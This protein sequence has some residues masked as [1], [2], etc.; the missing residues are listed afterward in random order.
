MKS[1][2]WFKIHLS[3]K[4]LEASKFWDLAWDRTGLVTSSNNNYFDCDNDQSKFNIFGN[5]IRMNTFN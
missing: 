1:I 4:L 5:Q 3:E 2:C